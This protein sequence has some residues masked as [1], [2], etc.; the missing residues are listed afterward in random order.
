MKQKLP[1]DLP[2][3]SYALLPP[4]AAKLSTIGGNSILGR[5]MTCSAC[6]E[7]EN[8]QRDADEMRFAFGGHAGCMNFRQ[9]ASKS[10][11]KTHTEKCASVA[12]NKIYVALQYL[13]AL[14]LNARFLHQ[15]I[16]NGHNVI[17]IN[18]AYHYL[19]AYLLWIE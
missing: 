18:L 5:E 17:E 4:H 16:C 12:T 14:S 7:V 11:F 6:N 3:N 10:I 1:L 8:A 13:A 9:P 2:K 19:F 15:P